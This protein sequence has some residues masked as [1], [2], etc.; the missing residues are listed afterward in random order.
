MTV[1]WHHGLESSCNS[2]T[3]D[4]ILTDT[5]WVPQVHPRWGIFS[6]IFQILYFWVRKVLPHLTSPSL[7][8]YN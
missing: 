2:A 8:L 7:L 1:Q 6:P 3:A 5:M 4:L